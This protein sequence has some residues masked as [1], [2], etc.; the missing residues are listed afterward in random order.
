[1]L[2]HAVAV[3]KINMNYIELQYSSLPTSIFLLFFLFL[4]SD[5]SCIVARGPKAGKDGAGSSSQATQGGQATASW[6]TEQ[7][8]WGL[9]T[10]CKLFHICHYTPV[11]Y[12]CYITAIFML[13]TAS[14]AIYNSVISSLNHFSNGLF[15]CLDILSGGRKTEVDYKSTKLR[16]H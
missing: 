13:P 5:K 12:Y 16:S 14:S 15:A 10:Y 6:W 9:E 2:A 8:R 4:S 1:M 3:H 11:L 7:N